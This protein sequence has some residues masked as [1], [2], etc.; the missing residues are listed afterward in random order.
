MAQKDY[1]AALGVSKGASEEEIK[2]AYRKMAM[3]YH[4]DRNQEDP[5][6]EQKFKEVQAA[7]EV[8]S[9]PQK[10]ATYDQYGHEGLEGMAGMGG[11]AGSP[12]G[13][14]FE[15]IFSDIFGQGGGGGR[16]AAQNRGGDLRYKLDLSLEDAVRGTTVQIRVPTWV[17]CSVCEGSGAAKGSKP[18]SCKMCG[19]HGQVR[20]QQGFFAIQQTCPSCHGAGQV[21]SDP[22][23]NCRGQGRVRDEKTLKV[24][25]PAG[26]DEGDRVRVP[27]EGEAGTNGAGN[28]DL[29]V[30]VHLREHAIFKREG[31]DLLC[32]APIGFSI[33]GLGGEIEVPTLAGKVKLKIP[34]GTQTGRVFRL[35]GKG[36]KSVRSGRTGD[37][38]CKVILETPVSLTKRQE[39]LLREF[40]QAGEAQKCMP[41]LSRWTEAVKRFFEEK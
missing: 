7:Y 9:N 40:E 8:L 33:A 22:C 16:T 27:G 32:E 24:T 6:A 1:Y 12:F 15:N 18:I 23:R 30:Q 10:R 3:K 35:A 36:V 13:D 31:D 21:I 4:P 28:G 34:P 41:K 25:I 5:S 2:K 17:N 29:Y 11:G 19:G 37:L 14:I 38:L 39:E 20:M 26:V